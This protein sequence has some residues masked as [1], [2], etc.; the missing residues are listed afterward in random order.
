MKM[1]IFNLIVLILIITTAGFKSFKSSLY[2][3]ETKKR[4]RPQQKNNK[5]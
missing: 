3:R 2:N 5:D 4:V 1:S